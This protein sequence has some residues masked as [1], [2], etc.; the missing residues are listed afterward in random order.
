MGETLFHLRVYQVPGFYNR[1]SLIVRRL[2]VVN[3]Y[4]LFYK[5]IDSVSNSVIY[6][7]PHYYRNVQYMEY[8][9]AGSYNDFLYWFTAS[10]TMGN[11]VLFYIILI[12]SGL[13]TQLY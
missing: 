5:I 4:S 2:F 6:Q 9:S 11:S 10:S 1:P 7:G 12:L 3:M 8:L 13:D